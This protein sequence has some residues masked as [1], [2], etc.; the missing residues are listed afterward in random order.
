MVERSKTLGSGPNL[1]KGAWVRT[2]LLSNFLLKQLIKPVDECLSQVFIKLNAFE[3]QLSY[4]TGK[5]IKYN[6]SLK[7]INLRDH[8]E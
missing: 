8:S 6:T 2:P 1:R 5:L 4:S 3:F 7:K